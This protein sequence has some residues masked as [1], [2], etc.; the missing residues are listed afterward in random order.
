MGTNNGEYMKLHLFEYS[1]HQLHNRVMYIFVTIRIE[2]KAMFLNLD[3]SKQ[4]VRL[5]GPKAWLSQNNNIPDASCH[6][7][8]DTWECAVHL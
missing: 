3:E 5:R 4:E 2:I 8:P 1:S 7:K 6:R